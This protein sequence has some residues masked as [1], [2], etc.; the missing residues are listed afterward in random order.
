MRILITG[1]NGQLGRELS[2]ALRDHHLT[3][4]DR[5]RF[6]VTSAGVVET[7]VSANPDVIIHAAAYTDVDGAEG[8]PDLAM[9]VNADGTERMA[10]AAARAGARMVYISTD[11][12]FDGLKGVPYVETDPPCPLNVYGRSKLEG[13]RRALACCP[14]AMVV[15][16]SWLYGRHGTN[17]VKTIV[18]LASQQP[19]LRVVADQRGSPTAAADLAIALANMITLTAWPIEPRTLH[20]AGSGECSWYE[21]ACEIVSLIGSSARVR[22]IST[23]ES[24]RRAR[25]PPYAVLANTVLARYG[26]VLPHWQDA[27][28]R[29]LSGCE[30]ID[31]LQG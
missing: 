23:A 6:D 11:Y 26:I 13:E 4:L 2:H 20:L 16:T 10:E 9:A 17:F 31:V 21:F 15:R 12:V 3:L 19:E 30:R 7:I 18:R 28:K 25:R 14:T 22:P 27:L 8:E 1:A 5:P 24:G 29:F